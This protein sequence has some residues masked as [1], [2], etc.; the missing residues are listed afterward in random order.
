MYEPHV[1]MRLQWAWLPSSRLLDFD[2][3]YPEYAKERVDKVHH[4]MTSGTSFHVQCARFRDNLQGLQNCL[5]V[6]E[7]PIV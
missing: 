5:P 2:S 4:R 7:L 6:F 1:S 3:G